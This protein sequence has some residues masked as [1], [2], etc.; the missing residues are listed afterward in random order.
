M[1]FLKDLF[2]DVDSAYAAAMTK[3]PTPRLTRIL[4]EAVEFQQPK[5]VG[6]FRPKLRYAHQGGSN[7]PVIVIHGNHVNALKDSYTRFL[8][9]S[10]RQAFQIVGTPLRIEFKQGN[11]PF[12]AEEKRKPKEGVVS[13]RRR[14]NALRKKMTDK[15]K[16]A[17]KKL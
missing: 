3:L 6:R 16:A 15:K 12:L 5:R 10:F 8:E 7:P 17:E 4:G 9:G 11:N 1:A 13:M 14:K 2:K